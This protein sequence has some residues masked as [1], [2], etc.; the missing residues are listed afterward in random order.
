MTVLKVLVE[1]I[2]DINKIHTKTLSSKC[3]VLRLGEGENTFEG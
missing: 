3:G 2:T 1:V